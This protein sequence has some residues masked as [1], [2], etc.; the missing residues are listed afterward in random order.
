MLEDDH[1]LGL[2]EVY[3]E[4]CA[5]QVLSNAVLLPYKNQATCPIFF[6]SS[7]AQ[8]KISILTYAV[9]AG[10]NGGGGRCM[11]ARMP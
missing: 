6:S 1:V 7:S 9:F 3:Q 10:V 8:I 4:G 5:T 11:G 2:G